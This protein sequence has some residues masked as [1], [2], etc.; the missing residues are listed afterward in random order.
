[1][2]STTAYTGAFENEVLQVLS[3]AKSARPH[4]IDSSIMAMMCVERD[5]R[6]YTE[7]LKAVLNQSVLPGT[8]VVVDC[9][10]RVHQIMQTT[11]QVRLNSNLFSGML[12]S[13][14]SSLPSLDAIHHNDLNVSNDYRDSSAPYE[15]HAQFLSLIHI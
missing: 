5:T 3:T 10:N 4:E 11:M 14:L 15:S 8:L 12:D 1:M 6:F 13:R 9:A 7:T 2:D